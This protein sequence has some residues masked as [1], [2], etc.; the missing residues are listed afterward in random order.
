LEVGSG[1]LEVR[2]ER[3]EKHHLVSI[4]V[5]VFCADPD[6]FKSECRKKIFTLSFFFTP[7]L[8]GGKK[9]GTIITSTIP[10]LT[11]RF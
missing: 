8:K 6:S 3:I 10:H 2:K 1:R 5:K 9:K 7:T 11:R 4:E